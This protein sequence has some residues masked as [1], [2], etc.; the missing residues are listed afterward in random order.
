MMLESG[1]HYETR[2]NLPGHRSAVQCQLHIILPDSG[3]SWLHVCPGLSWKVTGFFSYFSSMMPREADRS[4]SCTGPITHCTDVKAKRERPSSCDCTTIRHKAKRRSPLQSMT[5]HASASFER[6][7]MHRP[8][9]IHSTRICPEL[10][11]HTPLT[12]ALYA[13]AS[14][15][16]WQTHR[17]RSSSKSCHA[18]SGQQLTP[19][20]LRPVP[21]QRRQYPRY[22]RCGFHGHRGRY[23]TVARL[24][25]PDPICA[26]G[27]ATV[28]M[29]CSTLFGAE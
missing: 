28:R 12:M 7:L 21:G 2:W 23:A 14:D 11:H 5:A 27:A 22:C 17:P 19:Q 18:R 4:S 25:H 20:P 1:L 9:L 26:Q 24:Q 29:L 13:Q 16:S 3:T 10:L 6:P 15:L 8:T